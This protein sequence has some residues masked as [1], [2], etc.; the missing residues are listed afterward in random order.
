M[1][2]KC[3]YIHV[4]YMQWS[5]LGHTHAAL[6]DPCAFTPWLLLQP[7]STHSTTPAAHAHPQH[8]SC[9]INNVDNASRHSYSDIQTR[10]KYRHQSFSLCVVV[11][12]QEHAIHVPMNHSIADISSVLREGGGRLWKYYIIQTLLHYWKFCNNS[13]RGVYASGL[14][15]FYHIFIFSVT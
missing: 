13:L 9:T 2:L 10:A 12:T 15:K 1:F 11:I 3:A 4:G 8:D 5:N 7:M 6:P 14:N